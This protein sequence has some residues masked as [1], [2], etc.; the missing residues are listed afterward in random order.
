MNYI[1]VYT[2][3]IIPIV[4]VLHSQRDDLTVQ[5]TMWTKHIRTHK[6]KSKAN[7]TIC[8]IISADDSVTS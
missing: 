1:T 3:N 6:S 2:H 8:N 4:T 5:E 7:K